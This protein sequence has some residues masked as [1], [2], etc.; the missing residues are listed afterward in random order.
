LHSSSDVKEALSGTIYFLWHTGQQAA[1][2]QRNADDGADNGGQRN[3]K[4]T[5]S[6]DVNS[7]KPTLAVMVNQGSAERRHGEKGRNANQVVMRIHANHSRQV[8]LN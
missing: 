5:K 1:Y 4:R 8:M 3:G 2:G 7:R 6:R